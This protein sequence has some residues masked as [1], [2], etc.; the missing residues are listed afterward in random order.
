MFFRS[1]TITSNCKKV[2]FHLKSKMELSVPKDALRKVWFEIDL[3]VTGFNGP[4]PDIAFST[5]VSDYTY[6]CTCIF[7]YL[8]LI[9]FSLLIVP[10][11]RS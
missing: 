6:I 11:H 10:R 4:F 5:S 9:Q 1:L 3:V 2:A 8:Y 7:I